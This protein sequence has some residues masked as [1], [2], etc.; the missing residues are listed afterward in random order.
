MMNCYRIVLKIMRKHHN[1]ED[2]ANISSKDTFGTIAI[3]VAIFAVIG[4]YWRW[5]LPGAITWGDWWYYSKGSMADMTANLW[6]SGLGG[7]QIHSMPTAPLVMTSGFLFRV[8]GWSYSIIERVVCFFP[9]ILYLIISPWYLARVL[10]YR[11]AA[12]AAT[13]I[14][15]NLNTYVFFL[16]NITTMG[17]AIAFGPFVL[18]AFIKLIGN[19]RFR[20]T[21][22]FAFFAS[23]QIVYDLRIAYVFFFL[24]GLYLFYSA[25]LLLAKHKYD[26]GK[27][28]GKVV[29]ALFLIL[30]LHSYWVIPLFADKFSQGTGAVLPE[31][32]NNSA[33]IKVLSYW[34]LL[35]VFGLQSIFWG[36]PDIINPPNPRF[37]LLPILAVTVFLLSPHKRRKIFLFFGFALLIFAFFAKGSKP[38]FGKV[39]TW[40]F[41]HFPG[42]FM[43]RE[44][45]KWWSP[46]VLSYAVLFGGLVDYLSKPV[47][48]KHYLIW[49]PGKLK[50]PSRLAK[51]SFIGIIVFMFF[52]IFPVQPIST[53]KYSAMFTPYPVPDE[54]DKLDTF[55]HPQEGFFRILWLPVPYR[56]GYSSTQHPALSAISLGIE[57]L[58]PLF[59]GDPKYH[60]PYILSYLNKRDISALLRIFSIKYIVTPAVSNN[61]PFIYYWYEMPPQYYRKFPSSIAGIKTVDFEGKSKIYEL[62]DYLPHFYTTLKNKIIIGDYREALS[63]TYDMDFFKSKKPL[64]AIIKPSPGS[65][66]I[67]NASDYFI[68]Q[69]RDPNDLSIEFT[70]SSNLVCSFFTNLSKQT[71]DI[72]VKK[73]GIYELWIDRFMVPEA[74]DGFS[75][76]FRISKKGKTLQEIYFL[77]QGLTGKQESKYLKLG[78]F[79]DLKIGDYT[80]EIS[81]EDKSFKKAYSVSLLF[82]NKAEREALRDAIFEKI[83]Q[84]ESSVSYIFTRNGSFYAK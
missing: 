17:L 52:I 22:I 72:T 71:K 3:V 32:Y 2:K 81:F 23:I 34:N 67:L 80:I 38:P 16:T 27:I 20:E 15:F 60:W 46:I 48:I 68:F 56:F 49:L 59:S 50:I 75:A 69:D 36:K 25:V 77:L 62:P 55:L 44:P 30:L 76:V 73:S 53:L 8:F 6:G 61:S 7:Y 1:Q 19:P 40:F 83:M 84:E 35:H 47:N 41:L 37:L 79:D 63:G 51:I 4:L 58:E 21:I 45:G 13:I 28:A 18:A 12:A 82:V 9:L 54:A 31:G 26:L 74:T 5:F 65:E 39:Y 42:F 10:G 57:K 43:F 66:S 14:V 78:E 33:W 11:R 64:F 29:L 24:C 70:K